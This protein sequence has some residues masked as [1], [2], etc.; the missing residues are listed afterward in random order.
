MS[1]MELVHAPQ[2]SNSL[3]SPVSLLIKLKNEPIAPKTSAKIV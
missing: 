3:K 1:V 2:I